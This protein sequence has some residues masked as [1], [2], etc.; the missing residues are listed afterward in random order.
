MVLIASA[1]GTAFVGRE[2]SHVT[3]Q[4]PV[5]LEQGP[6][7]TVLHSDVVNLVVMSSLR[8]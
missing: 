6:Q 8:P 2:S 5:T 7:L 1:V 4:I 3:L